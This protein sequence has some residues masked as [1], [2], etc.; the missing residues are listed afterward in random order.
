MPAVL[1]KAYD[2]SGEAVG[3]FDPV[4][5]EQRDWIVENHLPL[6]MDF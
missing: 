5:L 1:R 6:P 3:E 2:M 4:L